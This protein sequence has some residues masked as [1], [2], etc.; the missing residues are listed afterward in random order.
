MGTR[1]G[2]TTDA[3][4]KRLA[5]EIVAQHER[6][7]KLT[8]RRYSLCAADAEDA[9]Q[10]ALEILL[11]KAPVGD[12]RELIRWMQTVT[13]HEALAVRR[14][15]ERLLSGT[16]V[17]MAGGDEE[18]D[19][20]ALIPAPT[21]GPAERAER[22][23]AV[24][25]SREALQALKPAERRALTLLAEG[26]SYAEISQL[27]GFSP[28]KVNRCLAE[29]RER[30]RTLLMRSQDGSRCKELRPLLSAFCDGE[31]SPKEVA[32]MREHL[33]ACAPCRA[34]MRAYKAAP[35]A[36]AALVPTLPPISE[37]LLDR[38]R[39]AFGELQAHLTTRGGGVDAGGQAAASAGAGSGGAAT[40]TKAIGVC[41]TAVGGTAACVAVGIVPAPLGLTASTTSSP[42]ERGAERTGSRAQ[43]ERESPARPKARRPEPEQRD[44][45]QA[46]RGGESA[47]NAETAQASVVE[48]EPAPVPE[49]TPAPEPVPA[50]EPAPPP[51]ATGEPTGSE[52]A[53]GEFG[54]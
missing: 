3:R 21:D 25:R 7:L 23:E 5:V 22:H 42:I 29:G 41:A 45:T 39:E 28:T 6:A 37:S 40:L 4:R 32:T 2:E 47:T 15:R 34:A 30:F 24:A 1:G 43:H 51:A 54:P 50:P 38:L 20:M 46:N 52:G 8:A 44:R 48:P 27:T 13:K 31:A 35:G 36:A 12:A 33:R 16:P 18:E 9:Y 26:Y 10:R 19:W 53:A 49:P 14:N 17:S 11:T